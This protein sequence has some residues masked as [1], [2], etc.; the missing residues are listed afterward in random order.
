M[1][2]VRLGRVV[3]PPLTF[4][5][6][7][8][9]LAMFLASGVVANFI[10]PLAPALEALPLVPGRVL[11]GQ[12]WRLLSYALLH[13]LG[14]PFHLLLNGLMI[15]FFGRELEARWG[16]GRYVLF[17][18]LTV[19]VGGLFVLGTTVTGIG[20]GLP[21]I[22]ASAF[23][24]GL[25]VAWGL[26]YRDREVRL[27]FTLPVRGIH[28]VWIAVA[29]WVLDA[30]SLSTTSASAHLGGMVTG[31]VMVLGFW[32]PNHLRAGWDALLVKLRLKKKPQLWVVPPPPGGGGGGSGGGGK[33]KGPGGWVH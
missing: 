26:T 13:D 14:N 30:V 32:R 6:L 24:E 2:P 19:F 28:M 3:L 25:I 8:G 1:K 17:F 21:A 33:G 7:I 27:F 9:L 31:A 18:V 5:I 10:A 29:F 16:A 22:G 15:F 12:V 4:G 23:S 20:R 11:E